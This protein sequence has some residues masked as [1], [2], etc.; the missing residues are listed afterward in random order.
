MPNLNKISTRFSDKEL[1]ALTSC[2]AKLGLVDRNGKPKISTFI[3][4]ALKSNTAY[5]TKLQTIINISKEKK[6]E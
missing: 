2:A 3:R 5:K 6:D 1:L 4:F